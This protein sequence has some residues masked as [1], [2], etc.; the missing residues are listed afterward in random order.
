MSK[1]F[2]CDNETQFYFTK[3]YNNFSLTSVDYFLCPN[4]GFVFSKTHAEMD[5]KQ[6]EKVNLVFHEDLEN[7][8]SGTTGDQTY[9]QLNHPPYL[10][11][12][13]MLNT[14]LKN[15]IIDLAS[16][17]DWGSGYG[18][19]SNVLNKYFDIHISNFDKYMEPQQ[20]FLSSSEIASK[21]F[22]TVINSAV[23]EHVTHRRFL[24]E[25][26]SYVSEDGCLIFHTVVCENIPKDPDWFYLTPPVHCAFHTNKSMGVLMGQW[27]YECSVYCPTSK[28]WILYK[29]K[30]D[31]IEEVV[32]NINDEL[33][34]DYLHFKMGFMDYW[35]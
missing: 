14:L 19:L 23:F 18:R 28:M 1:C 3:Q 16:C 21:K 7:F 35:K 5:A 34:A 20:N 10:Q 22:K 26:N 25:I 4:C 11:Q 9:L 8:D 32:R 29:R 2:I 12:A 6:W 13:V 33:Q 30:P 17:L 24:D 15:G 27:G 31:N